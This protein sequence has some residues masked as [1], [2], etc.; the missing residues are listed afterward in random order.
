MLQDPY[1]ILGVLPGSTPEEIRRV[2]LRRARQCHPDITG[3][4]ST[5]QQFQRITEAYNSIAD[6]DQT[7]ASSAPVRVTYA[8]WPPRPEESARPARKRTG[9]FFS[10]RK[11]KG[12]VKT[13]IEELLWLMSRVT[14]K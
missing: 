7:R 3:D 8:T 9:W 4:P 5:A 6:G 12:A 2:Y 10:G 13:E 1:K 11:K 14:R